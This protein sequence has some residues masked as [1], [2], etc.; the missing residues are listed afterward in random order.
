[1]HLPE[2]FRAVF[3][4]CF[5]L[6][7]AGTVGFVRFLLC[8]DGFNDSVLILPVLRQEGSRNIW[9]LGSAFTFS[10]ERGLFCWAG[11]I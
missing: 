8:L 10:E 3:R 5:P 2:R 9:L 11:R 4:L 6:P 7:S 1:M